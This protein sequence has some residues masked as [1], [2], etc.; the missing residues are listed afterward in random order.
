M[1]DHSNYPLKTDKKS[2]Q[3]HRLHTN[4]GMSFNQLKHTTRRHF[5]NSTNIAETLNKLKLQHNEAISNKACWKTK[6]KLSIL[7]IHSSKVEILVI[8]F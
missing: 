6:V 7:F 8:S 3:L 4:P 1:A 5:L 2:L